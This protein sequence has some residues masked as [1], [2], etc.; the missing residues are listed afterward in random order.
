MGRT[1]SKEEAFYVMEPYFVAARSL[2]VE[3]CATLGLDDQVKKT[4]LECSSDVRDSERHFAGTTLDGK[5]VVV[6]PEMAELPEDTVAAIMAHEFGHVVDHL[7]PAQFV[8]VEE[9]LMFV[10]DVDVSEP[11][12]IQAKM[13]R[14]RQWEKRPYHEIELLADLIAEQATGSRIG[15]CGKCLLQGLNRGIPRPKNLR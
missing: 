2:F 3:Y 15:Y 8:C 4:R 5:K 10:G 14:M 7:Y 13:A 6:A 9:Q 1:V 11:R 12:G